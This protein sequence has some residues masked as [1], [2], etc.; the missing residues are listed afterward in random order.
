[1]LDRAG[2][3]CDDSLLATSWLAVLLKTVT[4]EDYR[5]IVLK[6]FKLQRQPGIQVLT[7][8]VPA[9]RKPQSEP[10]HFACNALVS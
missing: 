9:I 3:G 10:A 1:M 7:N 8:F 4:H 6:V 5:A 2:S